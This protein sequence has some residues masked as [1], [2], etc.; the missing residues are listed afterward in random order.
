MEAGN[1]EA[2]IL[3]QLESMYVHEN[4]T[5]RQIGTK[6]RELGLINSIKVGT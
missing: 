1:P 5:R 6:L 3:D 4:R 2:D